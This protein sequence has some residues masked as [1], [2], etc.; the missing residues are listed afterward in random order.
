MLIHSKCNSLDVP[1]MAQQ[2]RIQLGTMR[3]RVPSLGL[4]QWAK[5]L[6]LLWPWR[7]PAAAALIRTLAWKPLSAIGAALK[8]K[9]K[10][11]SS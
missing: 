11:K 2:K 7:R 10:K 5:D 8:R 6:A 9:K 4:A 3:L 1:V